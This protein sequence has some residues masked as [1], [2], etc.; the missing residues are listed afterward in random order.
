MSF[1]IAI[2]FLFIYNLVVFNVIK[3]IIPPFF[4][5]VISCIK[6]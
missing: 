1:M 3:K 6:L 4:K 5:G 2:A